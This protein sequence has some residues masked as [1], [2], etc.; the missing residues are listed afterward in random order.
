MPNERGPIW[1]YL[2]HLSYNMWSDRE[3]APGTSNHTAARA[4]LRFDETLWNDLLQRMARARMNMVVLDLGDAVRYNSHPEIAVEGAWSPEK[5][6]AEVAKMREM[7]LEPIPKLNFSTAHDTWLKEYSRMVSTRKYYEVCA[8]LIR[9]VTD[10][11]DGPRF[12]HLGMDEEN[13]ANQRSHSI[14]ILRQ[15]ELW[16]DDLYFLFEEVQRGGARP[17]VW[18]DKLWYEPEEFAQKMPKIAVQSN[19]Y[20]GAEFNPESREARHDYGARQIRAYLKLAEL[21][22]DQVLCGSNFYEKALPE[23]LPPAP[24]DKPDGTPWRGAVNSDRMGEW[25]RDMLQNGQLAREHL[26][27]FMVAPWHPTLESHRDW[28]LAQV[29]E[30]QHGMELFFP[31]APQQPA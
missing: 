10:L 29:D 27:G 7:G 17:W 16:W 22:Y 25:A 19:W 12:F 3:A 2:V 21:G 4:D 30:L 26:L 8:D 1:S 9:E 20:Y 15:H 28:H 13:A 14:A 31:A 11:F 23:R 6:R 18:S 5:L 24:P